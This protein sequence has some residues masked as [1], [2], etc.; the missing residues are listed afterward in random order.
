[1]RMYK[2]P[3]AQRICSVIGTSLTGNALPGASLDPC[4]DE[5]E[6]HNRF[7]TIGV[8]CRELWQDP[9]AYEQ[10]L[11]TARQILSL[12]HDITFTHGD[13]LPHNIMVSDGH[14]SGV[15]D[16]ECAGWLP[17]HWEYTSAVRFRRFDPWW[18]DLVLSLAGYR[19][20]RELESESAKALLTEWSFSW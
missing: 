13:L 1:M 15:I 20:P 10:A 17:E 11:A 3:W 8:G 16:W 4:E 19:Y 12:S 2:N 6:F 9:D 18:S 5:S 14:I 7:I